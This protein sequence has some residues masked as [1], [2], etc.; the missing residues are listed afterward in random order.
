MSPFPQQLFVG[1]HH[2]AGLLGMRVAADSE[3]MV[4]LGEHKVLEERIRHIDI[5]VLTGVNDPRHGPL[6]FLE[7]MVK[8]GNL[9]EIGHSGGD[10]MDGF[11]FHGHWLSVSV[12]VSPYFFV[13]GISHTISRAQKA[14]KDCK[15]QC[16]SFW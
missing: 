4:W 16:P 15:S 7:G 5:V 3:M 9:H 13:L 14:Q 6:Q 12:C 10:E 2:P 8:R 1:H 11:S